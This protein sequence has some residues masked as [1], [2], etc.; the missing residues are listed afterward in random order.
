VNIEVLL[1]VRTILILLVLLTPAVSPPLAGMARMLRAGVAIDSPPVSFVDN[2][3]GQLRGV[4]PELASELAKVMGVEIVPV[5]LHK[6][7]R[8]E[9][10]ARGDIDFCVSELLDIQVRADFKTIVF[11]ESR[12]ERRIFVHKSQHTIGE[13]KDFAGKRVLVVR[14]DD[15]LRFIPQPDTVTIIVVDSQ[16]EAVEMLDREGAD[17]FL[18]PTSRIA[19]NNIHRK[20]L[21]NLKIV[22]DPLEVLQTGMLVRRDD[23]DLH[24]RLASAFNILVDNGVH[25]AMREKWSGREVSESFVQRYGEVVLP[26][27]VAGAGLILLSVGWNWS[28][29]RR[30]AT[31]RVDLEQSEQQF[32]QVIDSSPDRIYVTD[33]AGNVLRSNDPGGPRSLLEL[34]GDSQRCGMLKYLEGVGKK[35]ESPVAVFQADSLHGPSRFWE[36]AASSLGFGDNRDVLCCFARDISARKRMESELVQ[37][38]RLAVIGRMSACVAHEINNPLAIVR[39][40]IAL[41]RAF[42]VPEESRPF[43]EAIERNTDRAGKITHEL[44]DLAR[45][46]TLRPKT[47]DAVEVV[48]DCLSFLV[49]KMRDVSLS[50]P[51]PTHPQCLI[52]DEQLLQQ[53]FINL[54]LNA[55][56]SMDGSRPKHV[57][58]RFCDRPNLGYVRVSLEDNGCGMPREMLPVIFEPFVTSGKKGGFGLGLFIVRCI[59]EEHGGEVYVESEPGQGTRMVVELPGCSGIVED[60]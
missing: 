43:L 44:L 28:L 6:G 3:T 30:V 18:A 27:V 10:L 35:G 39:S 45:P 46:R 24:A 1:R 14:G 47:L 53:A 38:E 5:P 49:P 29:R 23:A 42:G 9:A 32:K 4:A 34:I 21:A 11:P 17:A 25:R 33:R 26:Y 51:E 59:I 48:R 2:S 22:G 60:A 55:V 8:R 37:A 16:A 12:L 7:E 50:M 20:G 15:Y 54:L 57:T 41:L 56:E 31:I 13:P 40:N 58:I 36:V 52:G 19:M